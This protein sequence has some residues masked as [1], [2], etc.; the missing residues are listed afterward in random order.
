MRLRAVAPFFGALALFAD[1]RPSR[2]TSTA[3]T[4]GDVI[5]FN[6]DYVDTLGALP[7][8]GLL[9]HELLHCALLHLP[10][11][12]TRD[13]LR[14]NVAADIVVNGI[15]AHVDER[16]LPPGA[17]R[18]KHL[19]QF[20]VEEVYELL[21]PNATLPPTL[22]DLTVAAIPDRR[23]QARWRAAAQH[24]AV[25]AETARQGNAALGH[26]REFE[27][28]SDARVD[29][30]AQL[31]R[32]LVQTPND[33]VDFDRRFIHQGLYLDS[34]AGESLDV[35]VAIDTSGSIDDELL[36]T[37]FTELRGIL[38]SYPHVRCELYYAD[39]GLY[40]PWP[41]TARSAM[42]KPVGGG[43]TSFV[44]FFEAIDNQRRPTRPAVSVYLT[45]GYGYF[46]EKPPRHPV[47]WV[48]TPGGL[49]AEHFPFGRVVRLWKHE[50]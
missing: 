39:N 46:P 30:R 15:I 4:D 34:L 36:A 22:A 23:V 29:W 48:V 13:P 17:L 41:L 43:G 21:P 28:L 26:E 45:D 11:R 25:I 2:E 31:W 12:G 47:L 10:R 49:P 42:P 1:F 3:A 27:Q 44:P 50:A 18:D 37:F 6:A 19:E 8:E 35:N 5:L 14:W 32:F 9:L 40:G 16:R 20:P 24:A 33:F 7:L 38:K